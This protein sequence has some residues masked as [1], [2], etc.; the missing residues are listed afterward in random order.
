MDSKVVATRSGDCIAAHDAFGAAQVFEHVFV[1][2]LTDAEG[3]GG[4]EAVVVTGFQLAA[5]HYGGFWGSSGVGM[6]FSG[7]CGGLSAAFCV[8]G[9]FGL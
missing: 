5:F 8:D 2:V 1:Y 9:C 4:H 7:W 6:G 3:W